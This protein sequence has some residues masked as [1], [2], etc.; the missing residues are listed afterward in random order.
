MKALI[1]ST[2]NRV[3]TENRLGCQT[4]YRVPLFGYAQ[5]SDHLFNQLK[6]AVGPGHL[7]PND[8]LPQAATVLAFFLPFTKELVASNRAHTYVARSWAS[9]YIDTNALLSLCCEEITNSLANQGVKAA[10]QE[11]THNFDP[12]ELCSL[13]SHKHVAYIC[14][15]G[16][17]GLHQMLITP[18]GCAGRFGSLVIDLPLSPSPR[19]TEKQCLFHL[20]GKCLA[21]VKKCPSGALTTEGLD[22]QKCYSYLLEV[23]SFYSDLGLCDVCGKCATCG[24]CAVID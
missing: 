1:E 9:A 2:V 6:K 4:A 21:C 24:P 13:W 10:W 14:G 3:I 17:F 8:L 19:Q 16:N 22:K 23:D 20:K 5:A 12:V 15:L 18:S 7:L 11:P